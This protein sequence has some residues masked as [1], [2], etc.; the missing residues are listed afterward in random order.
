M[1]RWSLNPILPG[2]SSNDALARLVGEL[3]HILAEQEQ[4][5]QQIRGEAGYTSK[6]SGTLDMQG[7]TIKGLPARPQNDDEAPSFHYLKS[8]SLLYTE[9]ASHYDT[10]R[11]I[12]HAEAQDAGESVTLEQTRRLIRQ[13]DLKDV[14]F[15]TMSLSDLLTNERVL[16]SSSTITVTDNGANNTVV[17]SIPTTT[18]TTG[19]Y[20]PTL[21]NV[22][23]LAA[24]TAYQCQ[25]IRVLDMVLVSGLV[26]VDT[27]TNGVQTRLGISIPIASNF[28]ANE[29]CAGAA[30]PI[31]SPA[32][33]AGIKADTT[34]DRAE[35]SWISDSTANR[36]MY[37]IF[38][39]Q[40]IE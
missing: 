34:N 11:R 14:P 32:I 17:P 35:M 21:T 12:R 19:T 1:S 37:F 25:Y 40:I 4:D 38:M 13:Q 22:A 30:L 15:V 6:L 20:T 33:G 24:S 16:T 3:N 5:A 28:G 10:K 29:D 2:E 26:D 9:N 27:T 8:G 39:Y 18:L 23:N 7:N 31:A 36:A